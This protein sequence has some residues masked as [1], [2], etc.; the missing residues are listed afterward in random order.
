[1]ENH[2]ECTEFIAV[3][4]RANADRFAQAPHRMRD[5]LLRAFLW[6]SVRSVLKSG[7]AQAVP[8]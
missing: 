8:E 6:F 2:G 3:I 7:G 4:F 5:P 1:M